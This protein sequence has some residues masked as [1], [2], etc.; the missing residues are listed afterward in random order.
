MNFKKKKTKIKSLA[1]SI[2]ATAYQSLE[3][4]VV[5]A[6]EINLIFPTKPLSD[7]SYNDK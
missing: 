3:P 6:E 2:S 7:S 4:T 1:K 5:F